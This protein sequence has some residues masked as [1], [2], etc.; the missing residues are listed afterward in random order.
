MDNPPLHE[1][2]VVQGVMTPVWRNWFNVLWMA[3]HGLDEAGTT[4][5]RPVKG[6]YEGKMYFDTTLGKPIWLKSV[7]PTVW[8]LADGT[9]A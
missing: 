2:M 4:A 9:A 7:R 6:L 3:T 1:N 5:N 8:V